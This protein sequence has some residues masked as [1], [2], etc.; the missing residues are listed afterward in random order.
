MESSFEQVL[1]DKALAQEKYQIASNILHDIGN[2]VIGLSSYVTRVKKSLEQDNSENLQN[3]AGFFKS[4][5]EAIASAIG[6]TKSDAI[7]KLVIGIAQT[8]KAGYQ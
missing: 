7:I 6:E 4:Q 3:L 5:H 8:Q 2:A 1:L